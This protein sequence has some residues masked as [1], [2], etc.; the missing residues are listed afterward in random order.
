MT[1]FCEWLHSLWG[2]L[3]ASIKGHWCRSLCLTYVF[4]P[5]SAATS[6]YLRSSPIFGGCSSRC[7][8]QKS[9]L[10]V[11]PP[12]G[13]FTGR[14]LGDCLTIVL[15]WHPI[16]SPLTEVVLCGVGQVTC[17]V[18]DGCPYTR[19]CQLLMQWEEVS[20]SGGH[21]TFHVGLLLH[22]R[23]HLLWSDTPPPKSPLP[24]YPWSSS[25]P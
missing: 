4:L 12:Q 6:H 1:Q 19:E 7:P 24:T 15:L 10:P 16:S 20:F 22:K 21:V 18:H 13:S 2:S 5:R 23:G 25:F 11:F 9:Q 17:P 8:W 3:S 14:S